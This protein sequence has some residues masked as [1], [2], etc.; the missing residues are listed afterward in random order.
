[1]NASRN[2][3]QREK[4]EQRNREKIPIFRSTRRR[5]AAFGNFVSVRLVKLQMAYGRSSFWIPFSPVFMRPAF[6]DTRGPHTEQDVEA[7]DGAHALRRIRRRQIKATRRSG[8][9][10]NETRREEEEP[11]ASKPD[12]RSVFARS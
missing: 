9:V 5:R 2:E 1:M 3:E 4:G 10:F 8:L 11:Q 6:A 7:E 12:R